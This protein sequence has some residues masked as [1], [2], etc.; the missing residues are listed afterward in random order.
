MVLAAI[1][2][3]AATWG[4]IQAGG[5]MPEP[6]LPVMSVKGSESP[7]GL[8]QGELDKLNKALDLIGE[9]YMLPADRK[10][11]IDG[12]LQGM[13][14]S[15][16]DPYSV[17]L[18]S[19]EAEKFTDTTHGEFTGI[20]ADLKKENGVIVVE[21]P[22]K[23]S[24]ADRA[25]LQPRDILLM[26]NGESLQG[27][28][29]SDAA[30]KIRGPKGTKAKLK[31]LRPGAKEPIE[32]EL[33]R[34]RIPLETVK[35]ELSPDG[36]GRLTI[37]QFSLNTPAQVEDELKS[38]EERGL[39][40]LVID[41]RNNPGGM[42]DSVR[43]IA[44]RLVPRGKVIVQYEYNDGRR[45]QE[46]SEGTEDSDKAY[47]IVVLTNKASASSAEI[48]AGAL[49]QS[50]GA[51]LVGE[52]TFGKGTVQI[53]Y[54]DDLGDGSLLKL[55]VSKWLLPDGTWI[56][57]KGIEPDLKVS[58]PAYWLAFR[59]PRDHALKRDDTGEDVK[60]LQQILEGV[61]FPA[62]RE[63]GYFSEATER[64]LKE[65]QRREGL[66]VSG[67][68]DARTADRLEESLYDQLQ[69]P[70]NDKQLQAALGKAREMAGIASA[71][72]RISSPAVESI[73]G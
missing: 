2:G 17:Y 73:G 28:S 62:D 20:G 42:T 72:G 34:D 27:L 25:G 41:V 21:S 56:H 63:D 7:E 35:A 37:S 33:V 40:A 11:L 30:A 8:R 32:L 59:L 52:T 23:G 57:H 12:A 38:M 70:E 65:F 4:A 19:E 61:G 68:T 60:N 18:S 49:R 46:V 36:I 48:L 71:A 53:S 58:Q 13:V 67:Q 45:V 50:A 66:P 5:L 54:G 51:K 44:D 26:V 16:G 22:L 64:S 14:E 1:A 55:T 39:K 47:P 9:H 24:P 69:K 10:A 6:E 3:G 29:L 31:V 15:L 43:K